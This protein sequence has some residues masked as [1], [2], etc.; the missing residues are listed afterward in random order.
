MNIVSQF[1]PDELIRQYKSS[2]LK[3]FTHRKAATEKKP[4]EEYTEADANDI[5]TQEI[6]RI[7]W[8]YWLQQI[9]FFVGR[10]IAHEAGELVFSTSV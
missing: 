6:N 10:L 8:R 5:D 9:P 2:L 3:K 7:W 4:A 1:K